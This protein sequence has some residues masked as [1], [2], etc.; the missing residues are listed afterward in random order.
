M[1]LCSP[2]LQN[3]S[4]YS[5]P[6]KIHT[7]WYSCWNHKHGVKEKERERERER[8][9][10]RGLQL[11]QFQLPTFRS[12][13]C[14]GADAWGTNSGADAEHM[15]E[16]WISLPRRGPQNQRLCVQVFMY[17]DARTLEPKLGAA[18]IHT[19]IEKY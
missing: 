19:E 12:W 15:E 2:D 18:I 4:T 1:V 5:Y 10:T 6:S 11:D 7:T 3:G 16:P 8:I 13:A 14:P 9:W 17:I